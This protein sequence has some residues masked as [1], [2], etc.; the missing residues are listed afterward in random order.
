[1]KRLLI[2]TILLLVATVLVTVVYF[3][4]LNATAQH[5]SLVMRSIP[6]DASLIFEFNNDKEFYDIFSGSKLFVNILGADKQGELEVLRK[7]IIQNPLLSKYLSG[8]NI[9][10]SLHPQTGNTIDFLLTMSVSKEFQPDVLDMLYKQRNNGLL[11]HTIDIEGKPGYV[12]YLSDLKKRFYLINKDEHTLSGSFSKEVITDCAKYDYRK[13]KQSFVLLSDQQSS[14]SL[15]NLYVNYRGLNSLTEQLFAVNTPDIFKTLRQYRAFGALSLNF[16]NNALIF[17]GSSQ[18]Q[19]NEDDSYLG[20][21][22]H[23]QPVVNRLKEIF[24]ST[25]AYSSAFAVSDPIKFESD[26]ADLETKTDIRDERKIVL[27]KVKKETGISLQKEFT[28]LLGNEFA[29]ITTHYHEKIGLVQIKDGTKLLSLL[30]NVSRMNSDN[31]GQFNYEKLP[32]ILLGDAFYI[33]KRPYF[34]VIDNYLVLTNSESELRSYNDTYTNRKFLVKTEGYDN[35]NNL[36]AERCNVAFFIQFR[37]AIQLFK[38]DM[39]TSFYD[40]LNTYGPG[41]KNLYG[42]AWQFTSSDKSFYTN[43]CMG[44]H[45]D[46]IAQKD[47]L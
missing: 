7:R 29:V 45:R 37:N 33:F 39:K 34:K 5:T 21:F 11:I 26:L 38:Q 4:H 24:P 9:F 43:F 15:A 32:Q 46:T 36:L 42:A 12:V 14:N 17:N 30:T 1:M 41:W 40:D 23:Q 19:N 25:M 3:R 18:P 10:L 47:T 13:A 27:N 35:F 31:T 28:G 6:D 8:Q 22:T 44:L 20:L 16:N 2:A